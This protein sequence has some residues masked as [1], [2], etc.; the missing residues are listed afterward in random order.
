MQTSFGASQLPTIKALSNDQSFLQNST[1]IWSTFSSA[2]FITY[3]CCVRWHPD[4]SISISS[5]FSHVTS[6][7]LVS[8]S[9][10]V[11]IAI[12]FMKLAISPLDTQFGLSG[13]CQRPTNFNCFCLCSAHSIQS[14][15][16]RSSHTPIVPILNNIYVIV[17]LF[18]L[19]HFMH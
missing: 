12:T 18:I 11:A 1:L 9:R 5:Y 8:H 3:N 15:T 2:Y 4:M 17:H 13:N 14:I 19:S 7:I 10:F 6:P 16:S